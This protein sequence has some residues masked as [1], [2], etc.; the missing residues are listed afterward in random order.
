M[1]DLNGLEGVAT[2]L[3]PFLKNISINLLLSLVSLM[4]LLVRA[5]VVFIVVCLSSNSIAR[6]DRSSKRNAYITYVGRPY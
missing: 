3:S 6:S 2:K 1:N 5:I 4:F